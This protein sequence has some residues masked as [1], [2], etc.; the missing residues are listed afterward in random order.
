MN[1]LTA[2]KREHSA[3]QNLQLKCFKVLVNLFKNSEDSM[4]L[5][6]TTKGAIKFLVTLISRVIKKEYLNYSPIWIEFMNLVDLMQRQDFV[7]TSRIIFD[8]CRFIMIA[9]P[10]LLDS[11][12]LEVDPEA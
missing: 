12:S 3:L 11:D 6:F 8:E 10:I 5:F 1:T 2:Y 7:E 4:K 9:S